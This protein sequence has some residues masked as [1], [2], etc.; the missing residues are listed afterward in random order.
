MLLKTKAESL[1]TIFSEKDFV[2]IKNLFLISL[3]ADKS[4]SW[5]SQRL[6][7]TYNQYGKWESGFKK[8]NWSD[9]VEI[10]V[11][12]KVKL[13]PEIIRIY[14]ISLGNKMLLGGYLLT[15]ILD[16]FFAGDIKE[17]A[18][19]LKAS[20]STLKRWLQKKQDVPVEK[21]FQALSY[22]PQ[23]FLLFLYTLQ[24]IKIP[25]KFE[26]KL[27]MYLEIYSTESLFPYIS[28][29]HAFINTKAYQS[30]KNH[31][32]ANIAS[33]LGLT[34]LQVKQG[35][36]LLLKNQAIK[37]VNKKYKLNLAGVEQKGIPNSDLIR[38]IRYWNYKTLCY[39]EKKAKNEIS[40]SI[41][42]LSG[43]R[44]VALSKDLSD[45][46]A[47]KLTETY[48]DIARMILEDESEPEVVRV[49]TLNFFDLTDAPNIDFSNDPELGL[50]PMTKS[51]FNQ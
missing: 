25:E 12:R 13:Y 26:K 5:M 23:L 1:E 43:Y 47:G 50:K 19:F 46:V 4:Q 33:Q 48:S 49:L 32:D 45:K 7:Y 22:R 8:L 34:V 38:S 39:L 14:N 51:G 40:S 3:R 31:S 21:V 36:E 6:G 15:A 41:R 11:L 18:K 24:V 27:N 30:A 10:C 20:E 29:I 9:F 35:M 44:V 37:L 2:E 42:N 28:G 17:F 16:S